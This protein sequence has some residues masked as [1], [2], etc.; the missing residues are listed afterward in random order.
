[1]PMSACLL[2]RAA[3]GDAADLS[4]LEGL[5]AVACRQPA[6]VLIVDRQIDQELIDGKLA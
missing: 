6:H 4:V 5:S 2:R 3:S 1:M